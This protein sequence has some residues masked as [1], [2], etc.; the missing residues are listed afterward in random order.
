MMQSLHNRAVRSLRSLVRSSSGATIVEM[1]ISLPLLMGLALGGIEIVNLAILELR[2]NQLAITVADNASRAKQTLV[3]S[4]PRFREYDANEV[5]AGAALQVKNLNFPTNGRVILSSL[6]MNSSGGQWIQW[7]R[8]WGATK[9]VSRYGVE[10]TGITG[11][12]FAGMGPTGK[13]M[14]ADDVKT[15]I[16]FVEVNYRYTPLFFTGIVNAM[17]LHTEAAL[18]V[19]DDR[20]LTRIYLSPPSVAST[21]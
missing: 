2:L 10:G 15:A 14:T 18:Y 21:C 12:A 3:S 8:C 5:F 11:T 7:Q 16:M 9:Y 13:K 20:D 19:R 17:D 1:A 4:A 6:Q